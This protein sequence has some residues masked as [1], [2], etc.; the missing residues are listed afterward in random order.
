MTEPGVASYFEIGSEQ[1]ADQTELQ[2]V[3]TGEIL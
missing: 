1:F 3:A 2:W